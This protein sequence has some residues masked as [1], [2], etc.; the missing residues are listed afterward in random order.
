MNRFTSS[1]FTLV[2]ALLAT[3]PAWAQD[4]AARLEEQCA[5]GVEKAN[6]LLK[7]V[8]EG[9]LKHDQAL[10]QLDEIDALVLRFAELDPRGA[11]PMKIELSSIRFWISK[12]KPLF[13]PGELEGKPKGDSSGPKPDPGPKPDAAPK[14]V[15]RHDAP[16]E[17]AW[18]VP[19]LPNDKNART[20]VL[21]AFMKAEDPRHRAWAAVR[22]PDVPRPA[23][24]ERLY[25]LLLGDGDESVRSAARDGLVGTQH[26]SVLDKIGEAVADARD[27]QLDVLFEILAARPDPRTVKA[28]FQIILDREKPLPNVNE[29]SQD[30]MKGFRDEIKTA[31]DSGWRKRVFDVFKGW[32]GSTVVEGVGR[33]AVQASDQRE[34]QEALLTLGLYGDG[35]AAALAVPFLTADDNP[36]RATALAT[37]EMIGIPSVPYLAQGLPRQ[38]TKL[39][40]YQALMNITQTRLGTEPRPWIQWWRENR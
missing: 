36:L 22:V 21:G 32:P 28:L 2:L 12:M 24:V 13:A 19:I 20:Q 26:T 17:P 11:E 9:E 4:D 15:P 40:C 6:G 23:L 25:E 30:A 27:D 33:Y 18:H 14:P 10:A 31:F 1:L 16:L 5:A 35:R 8:Q 29:R 7:R 3:L 39:W 38:S 37:V 34:R